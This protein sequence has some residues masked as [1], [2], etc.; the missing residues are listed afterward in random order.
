VDV[1]A[2]EELEMLFQLEDDEELE[3][4]Y[5]HSEVFLNITLVSLVL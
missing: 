3:S 1:L 5:F 4:A 2:R